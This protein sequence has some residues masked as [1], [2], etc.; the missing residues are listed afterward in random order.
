MD[1]LLVRSVL[2]LST[3]RPVLTSHFRR[4]LSELP[5]T[6]H[7]SRHPSSSSL[8]SVSS[9]SSACFILFFR[10][11]TRGGPHAIDRIL[12]LIRSNLRFKTN[13]SSSMSTSLTH[14]SSHPIA[15][16][17]PAGLGAR[18]QIA[19]PWDGK[20]R[21]IV[22]CDRS[23]SSNKVPPVVLNNLSEPRSPGLCFGECGSRHVKTKAST[24]D[25]RGAYRA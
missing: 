3:A 19:P 8:L 16:M 25:G 22:K 17:V 7:S 12:V 20:V 11:G 18:H 4:L 24:F 13:S 10:C 23:H 5:V 9:I 21:L 1:S 2:I 6:S 15:R 14:P